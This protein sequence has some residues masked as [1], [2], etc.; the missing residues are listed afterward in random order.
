MSRFLFS[1][2][3]F[4]WTLHQVQ[5]QA[6][7]LDQIRTQYPEDDAV[8]LF[9]R[10]HLHIEQSLTGELNVWLESEKETLI[11]NASHIAFSND[12]IFYTSFSSIE[13]IE[14]ETKVPVSKNKYRSAPVTDIEEQNVLESGIFYS[15]YK[16]KKIVYP[17]VENG[18][19]LRLRYEE[20]LSDLH[21]LSPFYF[22]SYAPV[23]ES[24]Y[25]VTFPASVE[26]AYVLYG[27][28]QQ[29]IQFEESK[30]NGFTTYTWR[31]KN[32]PKFTTE[33]GAPSKN[34]Y[35]PHVIVRI[36]RYQKD[37][38]MVNVLRDETD[39]YSWYYHLLQQMPDEDETEIENI[40]RDL[41]SGL[42]REY[43]KAKAIFNWVQTNIQ[44]IAFEDGMGGFIPR[45][46]QSVCTKR[47]GDCKDMA[48]LLARM[49][50][51]AGLEAY[52]T[53][54]GTRSKPYS[55]YEVPT[56]IVDNHMITT[57]VLDG[58]TYFLD[59][60]GKYTPFP[61]PTPMIQDKEAM[62]GIGDGQFEIKKAPIVEKERNLLIDS[63]WLEIHD[64]DLVGRAARYAKGFFQL[65]LDA[66]RN[67]VE[68]KSSDRFWNDYLT[69]GNNKFALTDFSAQS[70]RSDLAAGVSI[71]YEFKLPG[72]A[73]QI[74]NRLL[75]NMHLNRRLQNANIDLS[76]RKY[77]REFEFRYIHRDVNTLQI[78]EG[79]TV[80][81]LPQSLAYENEY[82]GFHIRYNQRDRQIVLEKEIYINTL[83]LKKENF[84][85]WNGMIEKLV[86]AYREVVVLS[87]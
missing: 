74:G 50:N 75:V 54:I 10:E 17:A 18:S 45:P 51:H 26:L 49:L 52:P 55:Y 20:R 7:D 80:S 5:A 59:A 25:S 13:N 79:Y 64:R 9:Q 21:M 69:K 86:N 4:G 42:D 44:Y 66:K 30:S 70:V 83:M 67:L 77:E 12:A 14:A 46:A 85:A 87:K 62:I 2:I 56:P 40:T 53:W 82:F 15:D 84:E 22:D 19:I 38:Q 6:I 1:F 23:L 57:L 35:S 29:Q 43:D 27:Q 71:P 73:R 34:Y 28:N 3:I 63:T 72:Y 76:K 39:L 68:E 65:D 58:Q 32:M 11:L 24:E 61:L 36:K 31:A 33:E 41:I 78:P 8:F 60:T 47:Y 37:G 48:N 81:Y 16:R